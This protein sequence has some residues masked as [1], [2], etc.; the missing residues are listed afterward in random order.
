MISFINN[1]LGNWHICVSALVEASIIETGGNS[2]GTGW[3]NTHTGLID[4]EGL[5][6]TTAD[7]STH[8]KC[9]VSQKGSTERAFLSMKLAAPKTI[10]RLQLAFRTQGS[11]N[12]G[13][14]V[15]VQVGTSAQ[16]NANDPVCMLIDQLGGTGLIDYDCDQ[17]HEGQYV[18]LSND[19]DYLTICEAKVI[20]VG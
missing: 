11:T 3:D 14:N 6:G 16:Y 18:I 9:A 2:A 7:V 8:S 12:Q 4:N 10:L 19:Q 13:Q 1:Q 20:V 15:L 17:H 5:E